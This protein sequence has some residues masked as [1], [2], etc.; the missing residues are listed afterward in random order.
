MAHESFELILKQKMKRLMLRPFKYWKAYQAGIINKDGELLRKPTSNEKQWYTVFEE[1]I[2]RIKY[3][4]LKYVP[5]KGFARYKLMKEFMD[6]FVYDEKKYEHLLVKEEKDI[7][8]IV[9]DFTNKNIE[10]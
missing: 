2:R 9:Y 1:L 6:G 3:F 5:N 10:I 7:E 8:K 4:F